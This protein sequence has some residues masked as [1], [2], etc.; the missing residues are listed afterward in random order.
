MGLSMDEVAE[1]P[2]PR[3]ENHFK[4]RVFDQSV[5][6]LRNDVQRRSQVCVPETRD[7]DAF[8]SNGSQHTGAYRLGLTAIWLLIQDADTVWMFL[9]QC[10]EH[11]QGSRPCCHR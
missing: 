9:P 3:A 8:E 4:I 6:Q 1:K 11:V 2:H 7:G 5:Q 10:L